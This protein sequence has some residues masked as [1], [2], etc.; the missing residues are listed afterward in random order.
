MSKNR[1]K[2]K[3]LI[4]YG[5][6]FLPFFLSHHPECEKF[7]NHVIKCGN[8]GLCI[9]CFIGY[10]TAFLAFMIFRILNISNIISS[11]SIIIISLIFLTTFFL[12]PLNLIKGKRL[13]ILQK[14][15]IGIGAALLFY[16]I[17]ELPNSRKTNL[18]IGFIILNFLLT[19]LNL[20]HVYGFLKTCYKCESP[21]DWGNC[22][23]FCAIRERMEKY[24]LKNILINLERFSYRLKEKRD[25]KLSKI[26][27]TT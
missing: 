4:L 15:I 5:K 19:S 7:K 12:S 26:A 10:P 14:F 25:H 9:G 27:L 24:N 21:F 13:K 18:L 1:G 16:W 22:T 2:L 6:S 23:G 20:Y 8:Q 17:M 11:N 3:K